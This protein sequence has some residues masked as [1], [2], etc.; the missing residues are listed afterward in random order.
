MTTISSVC[1]VHA[2]LAFESKNG[3]KAA[4]VPGHPE[5]KKG[6]DWAK[7]QRVADTAISKWSVCTISAA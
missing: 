1:V 4:G 5:Y 6:G 3:G 2:F 7:R